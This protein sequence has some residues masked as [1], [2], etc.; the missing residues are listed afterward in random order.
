MS[1]LSLKRAVQQALADR[2]L[3]PSDAIAVHARDGEVV[4][5]GTLGSPLQRLAAARTALLGTLRRMRTPFGRSCAIARADAI[6]RREARGPPQSSQVT[7]VEEQPQLPADAR[8]GAVDARQ[9]LR[10]CPGRAIGRGLQ[11]QSPAA[12]LA[13][14][15]MKSTS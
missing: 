12:A 9:S 7:R 4:L 6:S 10:F 3:V 11:G 13:Q 5:R 2:H 14:V 1:D 15:C 8:L